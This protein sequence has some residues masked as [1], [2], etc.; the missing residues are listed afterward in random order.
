MAA[1]VLACVLSLA[2]LP[3]LL[4]PAAAPRPK[5]VPTAPVDVVAEETAGLQALPPEAS[6]RASA[7]IAVREEPLPPPEDPAPPARAIAAA[8]PA[9]PRAPVP[10]VRRSWLSVPAVGLE[11]PVIC[12]YRDWS[13]Q[14]IPAHGVVTIDARAG[15]NNLY[16]LGHNPGVFSS[17]L[18]AG[19]GTAVRYWDDG[20]GL[21]EFIVQARY[22]VPRTDP[23]PLTASYG[24]LTLTLQTCLTGTTSTVWVWRAASR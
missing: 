10:T 23:S 21:R 12:C 19:P 5:A 13:G 15:A 17:L 1:R 7:V 22:R 3:L 18:G 8:P 11:L 24:A 20:G 6:A 14:V 9:A 2:A 4:G 16:L